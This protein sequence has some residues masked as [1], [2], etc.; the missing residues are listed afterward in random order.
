MKNRSLIIGSTL[1]A[2][3]ILLGLSAPYLPFVDKN[4]TEHGLIRNSDGKLLVPPFPPSM[5]FPLGSNHKGVDILS[6]ILIGTKETFIVVFATAILRYLLAIPLGIGA[7][8]FR[9]V[10]ALLKG[11][12]QL[13]SYLPPIFFVGV[14]VG[15]PF[16]IFSHYHSLWMIFVIAIIEVGRVSDIFLKNM[17]ETNKKPFVESGIVTGCTRFT[18]FKKYFWP[19]L[20]PHVFTNFFN[21]LGRILFLIA[22][23]G[24]VAIFISH[25]FFSTLN[26]AY[27]IA[28]SSNAWPTLLID[29][30]NNIWGKTWIPYSA[31]TIITITLF[32]LHLISNGLE[33]YFQRK[34]NKSQGV[35]V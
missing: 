11:L 32:S 2:I 5:E 21:D 13:F 20:Q 6:I 1:F 19:E 4:L 8:Y 14:I 30:L 10:K 29:L 31:I 27:V 9:F 16:I 17:E 3:I 23:L 18:L 25:E 33:N 7:F 35:G 26:G 22:Q 28:N 15:L 12:N 24:I 34:T